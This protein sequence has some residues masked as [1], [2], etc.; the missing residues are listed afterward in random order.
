MKFIIVAII[1]LLPQGSGF[2]PQQK[3][4]DVAKTQLCEKFLQD[5]FNE[6]LKYIKPF[7]N[8][9]SCL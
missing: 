8:K 5:E 6:C 2:E 1:V 7:Y 4:F 9:V 3:C